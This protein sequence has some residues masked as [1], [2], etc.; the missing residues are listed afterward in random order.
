MKYLF[1]F[2]LMFMVQ[3]S[4][5]IIE[6][7]QIR[8]T[9][10]EPMDSAGF[11]NISNWSVTETSTGNSLTVMGGGIDESRQPLQGFTEFILIMEVGA[12]KFGK[13]YRVEVIGVRDLAG[14]FIAGA[15]FVFFV[16]TF[17]SSVIPKPTVQFGKETELTGIYYLIITGGNQFTDNLGRDWMSDYGYTGGITVDRGFIVI[18]NTFDPEIYRTERYGIGMSYSIPVLNSLYDV[19]LHFAE[20]YVGITRSGQRVFTVNV[21]GQQSTNIDIFAET[22]GRRIALIR[23]FANVFVQD[24]T[25]DIT[26]FQIAQAP[27][28]N[29]IE[30][31]QVR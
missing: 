15:N 4:A 11:K 2:L 27:L 19:K 31:L 8:L 29:G 6:S 24:G 5:Q 22:G 23:T 10:S 7:N 17:R 28:I 3:V 14:N 16:T 30:I 20:T 26:F 1:V 9:F 12:L 25:L 21:E 13:L 18:S